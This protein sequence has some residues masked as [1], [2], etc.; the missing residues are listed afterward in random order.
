MASMLANT[1]AN[2]HFHVISSRL[3]DEN[4]VKLSSLSERFSHTCLSFHEFTFDCEGFEIGNSH[5]T[6]ET[7]YRFYLPE[8]LPNLERI[9]YIDGDT[10]VNGD[11]SELW[12]IDLGKHTVGVVVDFHDRIHKERNKAIGFSDD[13]LYFNA[14]IML[15]NLRKFEKYLFIQQIPTIIPELYKRFKKINKK[16]FHD[17][18]LLNYRFNADKSALFLPVKYNFMD[19][20]IA[21][22]KAQLPFRRSC[23]E[24]KDWASAYSN[25][26]VIHYGGDNKPFPLDGKFKPLYHWRLYYKYKALTPFYDPL[27]EER[28][29]EYDRREQLTKTEALIPTDIY[30]QLFWQDIFLNSAKR[31]KQVIGNRKL[32]YWGAGLHITN[33]M[34]IFASDGLYPDAVVDGL[35][36]NH[37]KTVFEY[38][39]QPAEMLRGKFDEYFVVLCMETKQV[40]DIVIKLLKEYGYDENGFA[41]AYAEAY[42]RE[43][44]PLL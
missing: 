23:Y 16:F 20:N 8:I 10:V 5:Y 24:L 2:V 14:G 39:I 41:H 31:V 21:N 11:I 1:K 7:Y 25:P 27:D 42:E 17:Q 40:R 22:Y 32:A 33:I 6:A 29:A 38:T 28:I 34:A 35:A 12:N 3:N 26:I 43:D 18:E 37:G 9:L 19:I 13:D 44:K 36:S 15:I 4:K 30:I